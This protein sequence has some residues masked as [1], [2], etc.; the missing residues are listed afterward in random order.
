MV[1]ISWGLMVIPSDWLAVCGGV[2]ESVAVTVKVVAPTAVGVP[3]M[4]APLKLSPAGRLPLVTLQ[5]IVP[6]PPEEVSD[7]S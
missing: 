4:A 5:V 1:M 6:V 7:A 2:P 3:E